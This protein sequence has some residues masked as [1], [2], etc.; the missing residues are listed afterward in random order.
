MKSSC[1]NGNGAVW[2]TSLPSTSSDANTT[3]L[4][5]SGA[6]LR[7]WRNS[8]LVIFSLLSNS[9]V[10]QTRLTDGSMKNFVLSALLDSY[11]PPSLTSFISV[12]AF[13]AH[14]KPEISCWNV[15]SPKKLS[16]V[17]KSSSLLKRSTP[18]SYT[19]LT[20]PTKRIV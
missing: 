17:I 10:V 19:H 2:S 4:N 1:S 9:S 11:S 3:S 20:L 7:I 13:L 15:S 14:N 16:S 5:L 6:A 12:Y 8:S 18:V